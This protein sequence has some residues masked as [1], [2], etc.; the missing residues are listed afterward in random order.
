MS[1][2]FSTR[3]ILSEIFY[4]HL[5][6][7]KSFKSYSINILTLVQELF[8]VHRFTPKHVTNKNLNTRKKF[9]R[10]QSSHIFIQFSCCFILFY[11]KK[12]EYS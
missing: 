8:P 2:S 11:S 1:I 7:N 4:I 6:E 9:P 3:D 10:N 12:K 5:H